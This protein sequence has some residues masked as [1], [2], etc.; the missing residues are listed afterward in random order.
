MD[1]SYMPI[2]ISIEDRKILIVGGGQ[3]A[4][5]KLETLLDFGADITLVAPEPD[6]KIEYFAESGRIRL[7]KRKYESPEASQYGIVISAS[8]DI[9][10]NKTVSEDSKKAG[11]PVNVVDNPKL[12]D[13]IFPAVLK[14]DC[15]TV[16]V[17]SDGRAP[18][19][20]GHLKMV[21]DSIFQEKR[22]VTIAQLAAVFR[23]RVNRM[24]GDDHKK[25]NECFASFLE[26]DWQAILKEIP[27]NELSD[28]LDTLIVEDKKD[29]E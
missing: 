4:L 14:R 16:S 11:I 2:S 21:L 6:K 29:D 15:L 7:E 20:S 12:C 13:F 9:E 8:D 10:V 25:K 24:F 28:F 27:D 22:W 1:Y 5:R 18:F 3:V 26:T 19:L 23:L 17:S